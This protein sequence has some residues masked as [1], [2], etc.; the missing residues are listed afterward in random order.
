MHCFLTTALAC[1]AMTYNHSAT[2]MIVMMLAT[3]WIAGLISCSPIWIRAIVKP[4]FGKT[5]AYHT[6]LKDICLTVRR[7]ET[8]AML[9]NQKAKDQ[10]NLFN[11]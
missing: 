3:H 6:H 9:K 5:V 11:A 8:S 4:T 7:V 2:R 10:R 1:M